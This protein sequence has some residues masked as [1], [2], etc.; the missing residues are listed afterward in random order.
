MRIMHVKCMIP[1]YQLAQAT[2]RRNENFVSIY[3][4]VIVGVVASLF[5]QNM[6]MN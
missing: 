4:F 3:I 6:K 2:L 5:S 1:K